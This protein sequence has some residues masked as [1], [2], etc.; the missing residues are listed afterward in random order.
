M[1]EQADSLDL[2]GSQLVRLKDEKQK[3]LEENSQ[4]TELLSN[5]SAQLAL[6]DKRGDLGRHCPSD[7]LCDTGG[8]GS[9]SGYEQCGGRAL[10]P[11]GGPSCSADLKEEE[12]LA[13][14]KDKEITQLNEL[15][16][17]L[18]Y[19][20]SSLQ[21][22]SY[23]TEAKNIKLEAELLRLKKLL[24]TDVSDS[25]SQLSAQDLSFELSVHDKSDMSRAVQQARAETDKFR[26]SKIPMDAYEQ[27][28]PLP[29]VKPKIANC[30]LRSRSGNVSADLKTLTQNDL[31]RLLYER[32]ALS[33]HFS[34]AKKMLHALIVNHNDLQKRH[35]DAVDELENAKKNAVAADRLIS[36]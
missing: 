35:L 36:E 11:P 16:E 33:H 18:E 21:D 19:Q 34:T 30:A 12:S 2:Q 31:D 25:M 27:N 3:L 15:V 29:Q 13:C 22:L 24:H 26:A 28:Q 14:D 5:L 20:N 10:Q 23:S 17:A 1:S 9:G 7:A 6:A 8:G 4:L 32:D